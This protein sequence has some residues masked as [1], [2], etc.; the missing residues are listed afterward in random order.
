MER[1]GGMAR[2]PPE[3]LQAGVDYAS[4]L[5]RRLGPGSRRRE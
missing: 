3:Y 2:K 1:E 5:E 4:G